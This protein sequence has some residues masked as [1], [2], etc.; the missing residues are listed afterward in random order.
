[1]ATRQEKCKWC[2]AMMFIPVNSNTLECH[3]CRIVTILPPAINANSNINTVRPSANTTNRN[4]NGSRFSA[5]FSNSNIIA[6]GPSDTTPNSKIN[7][8]PNIRANMINTISAHRNSLWK[9][10]ARVH[11]T[12]NRI[13]QVQSLLRTQAVLMSP[14]PVQRRAVLCGVTYKRTPKAL[15]GSINDVLNMKRFLIENMGFPYAT[16]VVLTEDEKDPSRIPTKSNIRAALRWLVQGCQAGDSL[17]FHYSGHGSRVRDQDGDELDGYDSALCPVDY[18][19]EGRII[20]DE[21]NETIVRPLPRGAT[22]HAIIDTS[23]SGTFLDLPYMSR[24][25]RDGYYLWEDQ[26]VSH[27]YKG[28]NGGL[29]ISFSACDDHQT[30]GHTT[31]FTGTS[32]GTLTYSFIQTLEKEPKLTYGRALIAM[33]NKVQAAR[34]N[35][36][37]NGPD[38]QTQEPQLSASEQ[39]DIHAK[40]LSL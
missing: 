31:A 26:R 13:Q 22:L 32:A 20:D 30:S 33:R 24:V 21:I 25:Q 17:V 16:I 23:F 38:N 3:Q 11:Q 37:R 28:T 27:A 36:S 5:I 8:A 12:V 6:S 10:V 2:N 35:I 9:S 1:M 40:Q 4:I 34:K 39:F 18:E 19:V 7:A 14:A 15:E 29:A